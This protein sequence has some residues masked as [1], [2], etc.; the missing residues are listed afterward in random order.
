[1]LANFLDMQKSKHPSIKA[2]YATLFR[3]TNNFNERQVLARLF[4]SVAVT[5][6][7]FSTATKLR[8]IEQ[9]Y[10]VK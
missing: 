7:D 1:M 6:Q 5:R 2:S 10:Q 8:D 9:S 3:H 4:K